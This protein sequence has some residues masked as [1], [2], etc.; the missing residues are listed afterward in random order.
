MPGLN[1][2]EQLFD[3]VAGPRTCTGAAEASRRSPKSHNVAV[4]MPWAVISSAI[5]LRA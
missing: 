1:S 3:D 5:R 2:S 4:E